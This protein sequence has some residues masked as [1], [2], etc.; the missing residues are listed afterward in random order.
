MAGWVH[1]LTKL[2]IVLELGYSPIIGYRDHSLM[3]SEEM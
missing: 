1:G 2:A 3:V